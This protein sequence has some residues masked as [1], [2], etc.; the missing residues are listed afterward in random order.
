MSVIL[1]YSTIAISIILSLQVRSKPMT[2]VSSTCKVIL[3]E[4]NDG[5]EDKIEII[6]PNGISN[7]EMQEEKAQTFGGC[8]WRIYK[9]VSKHVE[10]VEI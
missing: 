2:I 8:C 9:Y 3:Y 1:F 10:F 7:L 4:D 6:N 5:Q